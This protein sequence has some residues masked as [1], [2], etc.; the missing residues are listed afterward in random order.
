MKCR[1][2]K[3][4]FFLLLLGAIFFLFNA[5]GAR[6]QDASWDWPRLIE[7]P[8]ES[9]PSLKAQWD[10]WGEPDRLDQPDGTGR[11]DRWDPWSFQFGVASIT[12]STI[13]DLLLGRHESP[14]GPAKGNIYLLKA[15]YRLHEFDWTLF[16]HRVRPQLQLPA[17]LG[18]VDE[19]GRSPFFQYN[20]GISLRWRDFPWN[21]Y[22]Y[23][24]LE[25][26][27]GLTY[28]DH[29]LAT[30]RQRHPDRERSHLEFYWPIELSLAHPHHRQHQL[31]L[32][33]HHHS[34][35]ELFHK[36][37]ANSIGI[38]YRLV[39]GER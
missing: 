14:E 20:L 25:S 27:I 8:V 21:R 19:R 38:G 24:N 4:F 28:S 39:L 36:G 29:V 2:N 9:Q 22:V 35:G 7:P 10:E 23:T 16:G 6:A 33:L 13:D 34:G 15:S 11:D 3:P 37:G 17:V 5:T 18:I 31:V 26:G 12:G 32:F 30:E 1:L